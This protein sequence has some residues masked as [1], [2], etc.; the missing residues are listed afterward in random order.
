[1]YDCIVYTHLMCIYNTIIHLYVYKYTSFCIILDKIKIIIYIHY[2]SE[3]TH[4]C[5]EFEFTCK[6]GHCIS[7]EYICNTEDNCGD[8][9]DEEKCSNCLG[10]V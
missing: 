2:F 9:S 5:H 4:T 6:N 1:M 3:T 8:G 7:Y 10:E